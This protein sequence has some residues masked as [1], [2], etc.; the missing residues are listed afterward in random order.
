MLKNI[1]IF[2][3]WQMSQP[4]EGIKNANA[5]VKQLFPKFLQ[6]D[7]STYV[8]PN[9]YLKHLINTC[10]YQHECRKC[11]AIVVN[12]IWMSS[13]EYYSMSHMVFYQLINSCFLFAS[14]QNYGHVPFSFSWVYC[15]PEH[16][17]KGVGCWKEVL[18]LIKKKKKQ[19]F[20][21][22]CKSR[23]VHMTFCECGYRL[24]LIYRMHQIIGDVWMV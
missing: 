14:P 3:F 7:H 21:Q 22:I 8:L 17:Q 10:D 2:G 12:I 11:S 24:I 6:I 9:I 1:N 13:S 19:M 20:G 5:N 4:L 23:S 16:T 18:G 15:I